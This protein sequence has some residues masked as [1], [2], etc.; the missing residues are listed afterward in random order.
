MQFDVKLDTPIPG[1]RQKFL[2]DK[3]NKQRLIDLFSSLLVQDGISVRHAIADGD[4]D[5]LIIKE[6][7]TNANQ[8]AVVVHSFDTD[9]FIVLLYHINDDLFDIFIIT[10][11]GI[12]SIKKVA[13]ALDYD[14]LKCI[15]FIHAISGCDTVSATFGI[16]KLKAFRK[17][18]ISAHW[19]DMLKKFGVDTAD[20]NKHIKT[21]EKF[22]LSLYGK[23]GEKATSLNHLREILYGLPKYIPISRMPPTCRSFH[24]HALPPFLQVNTWT[25]LGTTLNAEDYG[26]T[27]DSYGNIIPKVTDRPAAPDYLLKEIKCSCEKPN[28]NGSKSTS[29]SCQKA[30]LLCTMLCKC[31]ALCENSE[32]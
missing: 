2:A 4:A 17:L 15:L 19:I 10:K 8:S 29:C 20:L 32:S 26:F 24:F 27:K 1:D 21:V 28:K 12:V 14:L 9:V 23:L 6:S 11:K 22:Y 7:L 3:T 31:D 30:G 16:G 5:T 18:K 13:K 25:H